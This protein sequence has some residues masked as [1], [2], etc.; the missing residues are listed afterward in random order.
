M[1]HKPVVRR[2]RA[3][4]DIEAAIA[5]YLSEAGVEIATNFADQLELTTRQ[6]AG[7]PGTGSPRYGLLVQISELRHWPV[8]GFPYLIFYIEK[9]NRIELARVLHESMDIPSWLE[10]TE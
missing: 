7:Q 10:E 8:V 1:I 6:I 4:D 2:R 3:D 5:Y 9:E